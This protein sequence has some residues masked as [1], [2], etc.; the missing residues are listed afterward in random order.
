MLFAVKWITQVFVSILAVTNDYSWLVTD[1]VAS[2]ALVQAN[3]TFPTPQ[4]LRQ[5]KIVHAQLVMEHLNHYWCTVGE[6]TA[7]R[8]HELQIKAAHDQYVAEQMAKGDKWDRWEV[9]PPTMHYHYHDNSQHTSNIF[10]NPTFIAEPSVSSCTALPEIP[11]IDSKRFIAKHRRLGT[12]EMNPAS[13]DLAFDLANFK[14]IGFAMIFISLVFWLVYRM[15]RFVSSLIEL[16]FKPKA[17]PPS[18]S[19]PASFPPPPTPKAAF[20]TPIISPKTSSWSPRGS[21]YSSDRGTK[22]TTPPATKQTLPE[23]ALPA[24]TLASTPPA[25]GTVDRGALPPT[26][27]EDDVP[28]DGECMPSRSCFPS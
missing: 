6:E 9:S 3:C 7:K 8:E 2:I 15:C 27:E 22:P 28:Y 20:L 11:G 24:P 14:A 17:N 23:S 25:A 16:L 4:C 13:I 1:P 12:G 18:S 10:V 5:A 26:V 19:P 21:V